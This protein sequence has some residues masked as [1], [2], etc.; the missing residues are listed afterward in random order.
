MLV[1]KP[2]QKIM[3]LRHK[4]DFGRPSSG[5]G[6]VEAAHLSGGDDGVDGCDRDGAE[7]DVVLAAGRDE[8]TLHTLLRVS[9]GW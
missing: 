2:L 3:I 4:G 8:D 6:G 9:R 5:C 1:Q 7:S